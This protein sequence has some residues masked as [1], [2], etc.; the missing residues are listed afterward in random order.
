MVKEFKCSELA[1]LVGGKA[2][3]DNSI[4][5]NVSFDVFVVKEIPVNKKTRKFQLI[6]DKTK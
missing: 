6:I 2:S 4:V 1:E 5:D 3:S